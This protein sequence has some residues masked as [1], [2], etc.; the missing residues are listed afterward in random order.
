[1]TISIKATMSNFNIILLLVKL[2]LISK[3]QCANICSSEGE[4]RGKQNCNSLIN[5]IFY[6]FILK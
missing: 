2:V 3:N 4:P 6:F 5:C 1:M